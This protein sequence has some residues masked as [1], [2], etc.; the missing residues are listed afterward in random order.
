MSFFLAPP[1]QE[2]GKHGTFKD[3]ERLLP[4]IKEMGFDVLF[5]QFIHRELNRKA[6]TTLSAGTT[7]RAPLVSAAM[8]AYKAIHPQLG[9]WT[10]TRL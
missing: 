4:R 5:P 3:A 6:K 2:S 8:K 9:Q 7:D 1:T 10:I